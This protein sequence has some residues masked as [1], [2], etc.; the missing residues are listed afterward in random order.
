[1]RWLIFF[2]GIM[3]KEGKAIETV[4]TRNATDVWIGRFDGGALLS[5]HSGNAATLAQVYKGCTQAT[6]H[7]TE[8]TNHPDVG[9]QRLSAA[10]KIVLDHLQ[11]TIYDS[12]GRSLTHYT[13]RL[14]DSP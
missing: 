9:E 10:L 5:P 8:G 3:E 6:G 7:P 2:V 13:L 12:Q 14:D 1:M 4:Y 11:R